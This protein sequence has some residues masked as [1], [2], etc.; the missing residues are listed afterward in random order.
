MQIEDELTFSVVEQTEVLSDPIPENQVSGADLIEAARSGYRFE[1]QRG[2]FI[3][4]GKRDQP[5]MFLRAGARERETVLRSLK[6]KP[7]KEAYELKAG[8]GI[9]PEGEDLEEI[10]LRIGSILDALVYLTGAVFV[11]ESH[12]EQNLAPRDWPAPGTKPEGVR[13][14]F[15]VRSSKEKPSAS[16]AIRYRN[17]WFY[18]EETDHESKGT[19]LLLGELFRL[20]LTETKSRQA[21]VLTLPVG[22]P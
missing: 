17:H 11:P 13:S 19:F 10:T 8:P 9:S 14:V 3:L 1:R 5:V 12:I 7:T 16:L 21:P 6:L 2:E 22:G 4:T 15:R 18:V 20:G